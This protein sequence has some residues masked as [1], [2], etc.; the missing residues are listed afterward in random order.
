MFRAT[1][2]AI[3]LF[4][5]A[6]LLVAAQ[7]L[8]SFSG[9]VSSSK[10][11]TNQLITE[12]TTTRLSIQLTAR[13][14]GNKILDIYEAQTQVLIAHY[15]LPEQCTAIK[16]GSF[17]LDVQP[18]TAYDFILNMVSG[19]THYDFDIADITGLP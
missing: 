13:Q 4:T 10:P 9:S 11:A 16:G 18:S 17:S 14:G 6:P 8:W 15:V 1:L 3:L 7:T 19:K 12:D 2:I 5:A